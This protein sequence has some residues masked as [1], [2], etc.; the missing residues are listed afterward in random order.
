[1][2]AVTLLGAVTFSTASG[3]K[4]VTATPAFGDLIIIIA[5]HT[6]NTA[7]VAPTDN[8]N[9]GS[10]YADI[11]SAWK[12]TSVDLMGIWARTSLI[13]S[14]T[15]TI[16]SHAPGATTG[17][18]LAVLKV[19]G[20]A[21]AGAICGRQVARQV[22]QASGTP[23]CAFGGAALTT[24]PLIGSVFN[25]ANPATLTPRGTPAWT[26]RA[27]VG[28]NTPASGLEIMSIDSGE[29][30]SSIAWGSSSASAFCSLVVELDAS[31]LP[32]LIYNPA[33]LILPP[34]LTR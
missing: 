29:T 6:G 11:F 34:L 20:M 21:K 24:N 32:S 8:N 30:G 18:G 3:T 14:P 10:S 27:D 23:T 1:M 33:R 26:E 12:N 7:A 28:Y 9:G 22:D 13:T 19:T 2:A 16:F 15:S 17:G 4:T 31:P 25:G 5:A